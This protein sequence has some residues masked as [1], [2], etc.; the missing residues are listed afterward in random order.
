[1]EDIEKNELTEIMEALVNK[2][3]SDFK[4]STQFLSSSPEESPHLHPDF[5]EINPEFRPD[6]L[7]Y[8]QKKDRHVIVEVKGISPDRDLSMG[9]VPSIKRIKV[10][11]ESIHPDVVLVSLSHVSQNLKKTFDNE[12]IRVIEHKNTANTVSDLV[13]YLQSESLTT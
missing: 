5:E 9:V 13:E 7:V 8:N 4:V 3:G 12:H 6:I 10:A 2:L 1:M 11:N